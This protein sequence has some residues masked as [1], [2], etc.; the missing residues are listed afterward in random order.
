[1]ER[2]L[3]RQT[4]SFS[5]GMTNVPSD[6]LSDDSELLESDGFIFKDGE[7]KPVQ[8][9]VKIT[10]GSP[11]EGKLVYV[12]KLA[13]YRNLITYIE[14]GTKL[15]CYIDF[16]DNQSTDRKTQTIEL[17]SKLLDIKHVGNTIVCATEEGI[18]Y[19]LY[20][21][22]TYKDLGKELPIPDISFSFTNEEEKTE[23]E[24]DR[25]VCRMR[26]FVSE[27]KTDGYGY[28]CY[29]ESGNF[30]GVKDSHD[31]AAK[32]TLDYHHIMNESDTEKYTNFQNAVKGH[33]AEAIEY[34]KNKNL[35]A[36]PFF[37]RTALRMF[38]GTTFARISNPIICYP[39]TKKNC[40]FGPCVY[41]SDKKNW[42]ITSNQIATGGDASWQY[43][44]ILNYS[45][46]NF[47]I[48][49]PNKD[50]WKDIIKEV[51][52][53]ASDDVV[54]FEIDSDWSFKTVS[55]LNGKVYYDYVAADHYSEKKITFNWHTYQARELIEPVY[56]T[57]RKIVDELLGKTQ[58][59]KLFSLELN[60]E[61]L[62]NIWHDASA[63]DETVSDVRIMPEGRLSNLKEQEQLKVDDYYGWTNLTSSKLF[64]YNNRINLIGVKRYP[65]KG[66]TI[67]RAGY[68]RDR[69]S[70]RLNSSH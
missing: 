67:F 70:T 26:T 65:F 43:M 59:Y 14:D 23:L 2:N 51:V 30:I 49:F 28:L 7:M 60:S 37:I 6:L 44:L 25:T 58:F 5:K 9:G 32:Y 64:S 17:G 1:M 62:D 3:E 15:K 13:D 29:D 42:I 24:K 21:G 39:S 22:N 10:G 18:H 35:F 19:I 20:K 40:K 12:H 50:D 63:Y 52:V 69:K 36:F 4:L 33:A 8:K 45:H 41:D 68:T 61:Y 66:F 48:D 38:D 11:I 54:P 31:G 53:F 27:V 57:E 34:T 16:K 56:K 46:L 55:E 47:K